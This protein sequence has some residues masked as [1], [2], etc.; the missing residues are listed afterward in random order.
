MDWGSKH[1]ICCC[2][3]C[4]LPP[5]CMNGGNSLEGSIKNSAMIVQG[6]QNDNEEYVKFTKA[7]EEKV[8]NVS[9]NAKV[10]IRFALLS[11]IESI[12]NDPARFR[13]LFY[14]I[15]SIIDCYNANGQDYAASYMYEG[16]IQQ[17]KISQ[18]LNG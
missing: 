1:L 4:H 12:R 9:S 15:P 5:C 14:N 10:L 7:I 2:R 6:F 13:S 16:Q 8:L 18:E 3:S 17:Q 11:I